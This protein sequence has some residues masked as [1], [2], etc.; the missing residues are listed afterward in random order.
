[1]WQA[2]RSE[3]HPQGLEL[4]TV[5]LDAQ[6]IESSRPFIEAAQP[7]HPSLIDERHVC[8]ELFG[9]VNIPM[10]VW[11]DER[12]MLVRPAEPAFPKRTSVA[13]IEPPADTTGLPE[14]TVGMLTEASKIR[15]DDGRWEEALR[16]W[17]AKG[18][19]SRFALSPV[20]VVA[21]SAPR[22]R[23]AALAAAHFELGQHCYAG[24]DE[25]GAVAHWREAH[26]LQPENWTYKRQAW[27]LA[28]EVPGPLGRYWQGPVEGK[29]WPYEG[30]W[31]TDI[32]A[33]G[34]E[35]YYPPL[36]L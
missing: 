3:L 17:V 4:V 28:G 1:V 21:R 18:A 14:R 5:S 32:R 20:E 27:S 35:N 19:E 36:D 34:A 16:D 23:E 24:G 15:G 6:G 26:R 8:D 11:I 30:D 31:L 10:G 2:L 9:F 7:E 29:Q 12:G 13:R 22:G 25:A 33:I